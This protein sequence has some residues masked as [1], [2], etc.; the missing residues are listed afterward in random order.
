MM[1]DMN[2]ERLNTLC[3]YTMKNYMKII[4]VTSNTDTKDA[5]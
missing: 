2:Y 5:V 1:K 4:H 3:T